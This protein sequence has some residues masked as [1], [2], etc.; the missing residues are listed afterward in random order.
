MIAIC[1]CATEI[2]YV[3]ELANELI[4]LQTKPTICIL[5]IKVQRRW[6]GILALRGVSY[7]RL[8]FKAM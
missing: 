4:L 1:A 8:V 6:L 2:F 3:C 7:A 5:T